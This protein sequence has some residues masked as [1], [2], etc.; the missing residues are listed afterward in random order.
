MNELAIVI[1]NWNKEKYVLN[2]IQSVLDSSIDSFDLIVVDNASTDNSVKSIKNRFGDQVQL[3]CNGENLGGSGGFNT[4][5]KYAV[6]N[7]YKYICL[8]D[9]DVIVEA[10][11]IKN[12]REYIQDNN[13]VGVVGAKIFVMETENFIQ[14]IGAQLHSSKFNIKL[15]YDQQYDNDQIPNV[16]DCDYVP[17]CA[18]M[19]SVENIKKFGFMDQEF[20]LYWDDIDWCYRMKKSGKKIVALNNAI[21]WHKRGGSTT[22]NTFPLYYFQRNRVQFYLTHLE[23]EKYTD[24]ATALF[25]EFA[26]FSYFGALKKR[27]NATK[28]FL[29][30]IEDALD[31]IRGKA[32]VNRIYNKETESTVLE[33]LMINEKRK[34]FLI[35]SEEEKFRNKGFAG[36]YSH[37]VSGLLKINPKLEIILYCDFNI[38]LTDEVKD[39]V[40]IKPLKTLNTYENVLRIKVVKHLLDYTNQESENVIYEYVLDSYQNFVSLH[41]LE[42]ILENYH[43]YRNII[44]NT[45]VPTFVQ[46]MSENSIIQ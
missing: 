36:Y 8:L 2:C 40:T 43:Q 21:V 9:N 41:N 28:T 18:L 30:A 1:C 16:V 37:I 26:R 4:G 19:T 42:Q 32:P 31:N 23:K 38:T 34:V 29:L 45:L 10:N 14:E 20:F 5:I 11:A 39:K 35:A 22:T 44:M 27:F 46:R 15:N 17:A 25:E 6:E 3:I 13:E 33:Q 12:M 7:N 24:F